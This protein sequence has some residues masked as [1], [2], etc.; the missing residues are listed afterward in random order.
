M[1]IIF[2]FSILL[3]SVSA[4]SKDECGY[5]QFEL[6]KCAGDKFRIYDAELN[7][8]YKIQMDY[9]ETSEAKEALKNAQLA[10]IKF[11][12]AACAYEAPYHRGSMWGM[13]LG[14]CKAHH[15]KARIKNMEYYLSCRDNGCP[16]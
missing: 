12:D 6:N 16:Y 3:I 5:T 2:F 14:L 1:K 7:R 8:L 15:T 11:R 9:L 4:F 10:W 13:Q